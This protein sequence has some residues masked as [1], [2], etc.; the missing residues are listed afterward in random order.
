MATTLNTRTIDPAAAGERYTRV[1]IALHWAIAAMIA[2]NLASGLLHD[3]LPHGLFALHVSSGIT[4]LALSI[5]RVGWRRT[6]RPQAP[7]DP[8]ERCPDA[9]QRCPPPYSRCLLSRR[10]DPCMC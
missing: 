9:R 4:I 1:A 8:A 7:P 5:V 10:A 2:Y 3:V 6:H